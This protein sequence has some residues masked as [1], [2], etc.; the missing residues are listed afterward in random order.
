MDNK[1]KSY[2]NFFILLLLFFWN[3]NGANY[4]IYFCS[5]LCV[6]KK[7]YFHVDQTTSF[8][9]YILCVTTGHS[10]FNSMINIHLFVVGLLMCGNNLL[11]SLK[12]YSLG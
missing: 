1:K 2:Q 9:L 11:W 3:N 7:N 8:T 12:M 5:T 4:F 6:D 10:L